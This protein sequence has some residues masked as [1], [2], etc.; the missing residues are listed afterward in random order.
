[1]TKMPTVFKMHNVCTNYKNRM[2]SSKFEVMGDNDGWER[3]GK[4]GG[5]VEVER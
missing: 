1:M 4:G 5:E 2:I 3:G